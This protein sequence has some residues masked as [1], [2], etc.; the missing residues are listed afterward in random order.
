MKSSLHPWKAV[1]LKAVVFLAFS[2]GEFKQMFALFLVV[3]QVRRIYGA[4]RAAKE[5]FMN[6]AIL[7]ARILTQ[8][9]GAA[10]ELTVK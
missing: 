10:L 3:W 6:N 2:H 1:L 7:S 4:E 5:F 9:T 8:I